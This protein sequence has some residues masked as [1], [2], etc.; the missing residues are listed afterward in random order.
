MHRF[1]PVCLGKKKAA[2]QYNM[3][4]C[5]DVGLLKMDFLGLKTMSILKKAADIVQATANT[6]VDYGHVPMDDPKT[7]E[8]L[9][10]GATLG[11]FQCESS[12]FQELIARLQPDRFEDM[13]ALVALYRPG[14]LM[15][16]MHISYCE[17][18][19]GREAIEYPHPVLEG[20]LAETYGLYIYQ[21]QVMNISRS[22]CG[23]TPGDADGLRKA[24]G[25][26]IIEVLMKYKERFINGAKEL[27]DFPEE[28]SQEMW[29][30]I[31]GFASYCFNKSHSAC[32][33]LIAYWTAFMKA[34]YFPAF[35][36]ANLIY[37]MGNKD[38]MTLFVQELKARG[39]SVLPPDIN[40]SGWEFTWTGEAVR[41][42]FGGIKGVGEGAAEHI[43]EVR[44]AGGPFGDL[45]E[46]AERIDTKPSQQTGDRTS[47][48]GRRL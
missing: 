29:E 22:L 21:E 6:T 48:Q 7:F 4:Q 43:M 47:D 15:A 23:F 35:M 46:L 30:N 8:L 36:T 39:I 44:E 33:G 26:K 14:P 1:A 18:K 42:G 10:E 28:K 16:G 32:Y 13:I 17:R 34:N 45:Y 41:F 37:E 9:G 2:A 31:L 5:E 25:K 12:G 3:V 11:V 20:I 24:M 38:K 40:E 19:H 27:H